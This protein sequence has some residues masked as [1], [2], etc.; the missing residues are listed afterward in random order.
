MTRPFQQYHKF[1][2]CDL[3]RDLWPTFKKNFYIGHNFFILRDRA[4]LF[5][6][7]VLYYMTF[8]TEPYILNL[9]PWPWPLIYFWKNFN[10]GHSFFILR[11]ILPLEISL[12]YFACVI[13]VTR[14]FQQYHKFWTCDLDRDLWPTFKKNFNIGQNFFIV[15]DRALLFGM[16]VLYYKTFSTEPYILKLWPWQWPLTYFWKNFNFGHSFFIL[17]DKAFIFGMCVPC[18]KAFSM[19]P[20]ILSV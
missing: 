18:D 20:L 15:R 6:M 7:W 4:L 3:D 2:T 11:D 13:L 9:W 14:P 17:R 10:I 5:G 19:V 1:W 12:S 16:C 8:S